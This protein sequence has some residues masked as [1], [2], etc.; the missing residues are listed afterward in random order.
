MIQLFNIPNHVIDTSKFSNML[1]D[2]VVEEFE[3]RF[4][5][6]VGAKYACSVNSATNA[7]FI[8]LLN[9]KEVI[10]VPSI[11]PPVVLN[12]IVT[13]NNFINFVDN[14]DW[15]GG[16][17]T[18]YESDE[19]KIIDS[20][21]RVVKDQFKNEANDNDLMIFSFYPTK[22]I[23]SCD[24][25]IIVSNDKQKIDHFKTLVMN[26][27]SF[28][29]HNWERKLKFPGYKMYM[30]S[31]QAHIAYANFNTY[32]DKLDKLNEI[33]DTYNSLLG[34]NNKSDHLYRIK[35]KNNKQFLSRMR[36]K[37]IVCGIHYE[38]QHNNPIYLY[39]T[40]IDNCPLSQQESLTTASI[41]FHEGL[42]KQDVQCI[43]KSVYEC[44]V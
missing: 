4:S 22:P 32:A 11:I 14:V 28:S 8:A 7:I 15:V 27:M 44:D 37:Q 13:S 6:Y 38:C 31:I 2:K 23:G 1:H 16:S 5:E 17:Y 24:G 19:Y 9:K 35:V 26:G 30:N 21:Q 43:V 18:L 10:N 34:L 25:G 36:D 20:A 41:P 40:P 29:E 12:A 42:D 39:H 3:H 33:R